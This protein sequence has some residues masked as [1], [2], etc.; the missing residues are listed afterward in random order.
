[1]SLEGTHPSLSFPRSESVTAV[2]VVDGRPD[3]V[4][5]SL[6]ALPRFAAPLPAY[7]KLGFPRPVSSRGEGLQVGDERVVHFAGG[8]GRPGD[9]RLRVEEHRSGR[10]VF[11]VLSDGTKLAHWLALG[12]SEV[13]FR[14]VAPGK[15]EVRWTIRYDR[16]LDPAWYFGPW[17]RYAVR[18]AAG[19]LIDTL[20]TPGAR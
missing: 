17:E 1:M 18:L 20:A 2:G 15:T 6:A 3:D 8:E 7:L 16:L 11:R 13:I 12:S 19:Y 14:E 9:L 4:E 5:K 10:V